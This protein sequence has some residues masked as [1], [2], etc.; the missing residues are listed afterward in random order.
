MDWYIECGGMYTIKGEKVFGRKIYID[1]EDTDRVNA[2]KKRFNNTDL[3]FTNYIYNE[4]DQNNSDIIGPLYLDFDTSIENSSSY[5]KVKLDTLMTIAFLNT[6]YHVPKD[7]IKIYFTGN[8]GFHVF[9][10]N[11]VFGIKPCKDL[12]SKYKEIAKQAYDNSISKTIDTR[13]YDKKRLLRAPHSINAKTGLYKIPLTEDELRKSSYS[14][15]LELAKR[16]RSDVVVNSYFVPMAQKAFEEKTMVKKVVRNSSNKS[17]IN[18]NY[19]IPICIK[20]IFHTGAMEGERNNTLV[21]LASA[22]LQKG[23]DLEE[24]IE[25]L[26][27]WNIDKNNPPLHDDEVEV[28]VRSAYNNLLN[29]RRYGCASLIDLGLCVGNQCKLYKNNER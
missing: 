12:N 28:T 26:K 25:V 17:F 19:E 9:V 27:D 10:S 24:A 6:E 21:I 8:K 15:M 3:Y 23:T 7:C 1:V 29:G 2:M 16:E 13:I 11:I 14:D 20:N 22:I 4:E 5:E 18:P